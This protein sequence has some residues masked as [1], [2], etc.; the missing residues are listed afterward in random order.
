MPGPAVERSSS[1]TFDKPIRGWGGKKRV[2]KPSFRG[3]SSEDGREKVSADLDRGFSGASSED[4]RTSVEASSRASVEASSRESRESVSGLFDKPIRGWGDKPSRRITRPT[5]REVQPEVEAPNSKAPPQHSASEAFD[6]PIRGWDGKKRVT[7]PSFQEAAGP[8]QPLAGPEPPPRPNPKAMPRTSSDAFDKPIRGWDAT[9][10]RVT[11]PSFQ[12]LSIEG[13]AE[14]PSPSP[15]DKTLERQSSASDTFTR[16]IRGWGGQKRVTKPSFQEA[17]PP[18]QIKIPRGAVPGT[19]LEY[20][21]EDGEMLR[22]SVREWG[23]FV[24]ARRGSQITFLQPFRHARKNAKVVVP[25]GKQPGDFMTLGEKRRMKILVPRGAKPG[26]VVE[27]TSSYGAAVRVTVP[28]GAVPGDVLVLDEPAP[29][30]GGGPLPPE[31]VAEAEPDEPEEEPAPQQHSGALHTGPHALV[32][33]GC[34]YVGSHL[35]LRLL[36]AGFMVTVLDNHCNSHLEAMG[37]VRSLATAAQASLLFHHDLDL[38]DGALLQATLSAVTQTKKVDVC[39]HLASLPAADQ[40]ALHPLKYHHANVA[41]TL[42]LLAVLQKYGVKKVVFASS[43][44]VYNDPTAN[45]LETAAVGGP[46]VVRGLAEYRSHKSLALCS[47]SFLSFLPFSLAR[48]VT[49]LPLANPFVSSSL[50]MFCLTR[51]PRALSYR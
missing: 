29:A 16:S 50:T 3:L 49:F 26:D 22:V 15:D 42:N 28:I 20:P 25:Y 33:G 40:A 2:T 46:N 13:A 11:K 17:K 9:T 41:V 14:E 44:H 35:V 36:E 12:G 7:K 21:S 8:G 30:L 32:T 47:F 23:A 43:A 37:R 39:V 19:V 34:G 1:E 6:K 51:N 27:A 5:F 45:T 4:G 18:V 24:C 10:K 38:E 48:R 31:P